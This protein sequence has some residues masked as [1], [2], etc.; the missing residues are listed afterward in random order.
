MV[1]RKWMLS[2]SWY[3]SEET[4]RFGEIKRI[5]PDNTQSVP[6]KQLRE[7][8]KD[9]L[10]HREV[11]KEVPPRVDILTLVSSLYQSFIVCLNGENAI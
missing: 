5:L 3:I 6:T 11:Y 8:E 9:G 2:L 7:F 4:R 1:G 10:L